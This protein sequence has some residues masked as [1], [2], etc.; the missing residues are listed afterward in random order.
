[1]QA[2]L[3]HNNSIDTIVKLYWYSTVIWVFVET[4]SLKW[5]INVFASCLI[6][7]FFFARIASILNELVGKIYTNREPCRRQT[8]NLS[9]RQ[10]CALH[11]A[12]TIYVLSNSH[13]VQC[14]STTIFCETEN[15]RNIWRVHFFHRMALHLLLSNRAVA[16]LILSWYIDKK[17]K[18]NYEIESRLIFFSLITYC[19]SVK[20]F[21]DIE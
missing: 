4:G 21:C 15:L 11:I 7:C 20:L 3:I 8:E 16:V 9:N 1:M 17:S 14:I 19:G 6:A 2:T 5:F 10:W 13:T 12:V 18:S